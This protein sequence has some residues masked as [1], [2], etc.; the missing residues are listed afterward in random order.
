MII[1]IMNIFLI[2]FFFDHLLDDHD[3]HDLT[4]YRCEI[5][6]AIKSW[7]KPNSTNILTD[8]FYTKFVAF[9]CLI[10]C[11]SLQ[12]S[13]TP[14]KHVNKAIEKLDNEEIRFCF[15]KDLEALYQKH[16]YGSVEF[17][18]KLADLI[19]GNASM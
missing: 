13:K 10:G 17:C 7:L 15:I 1:I 5:T 16:K 3:N 19:V 14:W 9:V 4:Q 6:S 18:F 8:I 2:F 12:H 11:S